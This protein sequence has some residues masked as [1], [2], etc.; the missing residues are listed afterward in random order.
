MKEEQFS[1]QRL[2]IRLLLGLTNPNMYTKDVNVEITNEYH[3]RCVSYSNEYTV[4]AAKH[5][6]VTHAT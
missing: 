5:G 4:Y 2:G 3:P 6:I 1:S